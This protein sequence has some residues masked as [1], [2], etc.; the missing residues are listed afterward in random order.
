MS[1]RKRTVGLIAFLKGN[2]DPQV[3]MPGCASYDQHHGGCL[4]AEGCKV[5]AGQ[6][7]GWFE[8]AVLPTAGDIGQ[9]EKIY[10]AYQTQV[11][12]EEP[13]IRQQIR[14]CPDCGAELGVRKRYCGKCAKRRRQGTY[15]RSRQQKKAGS[16]ATVNGNCP[17]NSAL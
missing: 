1:K 13:I 10:A 4:F 2:S 12:L 9:V 14:V 11:G 15:R 5:E 3:G 8:R 16:S 6:R 17:S 7:C